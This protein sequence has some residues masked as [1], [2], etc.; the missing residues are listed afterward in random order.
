MNSKI[1]YSIAAIAWTFSFAVFAQCVTDKEEPCG[2]SYQRECPDHDLTKMATCVSNGNKQ[3]NKDA[4]SGKSGLMPSSGSCEFV[5]SYVKNGETTF[6]GT[7]SVPWTGSKP[8][9]ES[10]NCPASTGTGT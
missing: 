1:K 5:C 6:C 2:A 3:L 9:P 7:N 10:A 8:N 4:T